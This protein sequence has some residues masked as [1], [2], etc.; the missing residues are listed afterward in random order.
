M[1]NKTVGEKRL[2]FYALNISVT[3]H[4]K[5]R[6]ETW[7]VSGEQSIVKKSPLSSHT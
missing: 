3:V 2:C 6:N 5:N 1:E 4:V 7:W